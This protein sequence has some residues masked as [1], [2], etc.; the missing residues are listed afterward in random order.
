MN[1]FDA[2]VNKRLI[3]TK[4]ENSGGINRLRFMGLK[5]KIQTVKLRNFY[6]F[7]PVEVLLDGFR[8]AIRKKTA[9]KVFVEVIDE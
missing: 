9:L 8:I 6:S 4:M 2:P 1:L 7:G 5:E 3:V